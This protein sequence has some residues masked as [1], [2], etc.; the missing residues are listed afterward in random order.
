MLLMIL[1]VQ[2]FLQNCTITL[3]SIV[4]G[5][6]DWSVDQRYTHLD[7]LNRGFVSRTRN[8][9]FQVRRHV[10]AGCCA[11]EENKTMVKQSEG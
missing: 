9:H 5:C 2:C 4:V 3:V 11:R 10:V 8:D 1:K 6:Y 7:Q